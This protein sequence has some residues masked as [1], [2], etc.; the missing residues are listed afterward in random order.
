MLPI[1]IIYIGDDE[2]VCHVCVK[3]PDG[4]DI[5]KTIEMSG[6]ISHYPH[7]LNDS[8]AIFGNIVPADTKLKSGDRIEILRPLKIDPMTKRRLRAQKQ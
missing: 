7:V 3:V 4:T 5:K 1:E 6:L 8:Y 2:T